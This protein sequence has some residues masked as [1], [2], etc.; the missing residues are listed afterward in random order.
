[1]HDKAHSLLIF[2]GNYVL[3]TFVHTDKNLI[4]G[5]HSGRRYC[6]HFIFI[7]H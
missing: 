4:F 1:M 6:Y 2:Y 3:Y 7:V 5:V